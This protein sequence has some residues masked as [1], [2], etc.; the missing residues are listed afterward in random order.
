M[1]TGFANGTILVSAGS[2]VAGAKTIRSEDRGY[3]WRPQSLVIAH[4]N[5]LE[6]NDGRMLVIEYNPKAIDDRPGYYRGKRWISKDQGRTL[7]EVAEGATL[8]LPA[9]KFDPKGVYWFH[10]N[11]IQLPNKQLLTVMQGKE[12]VE[13]KSTWQ[14][15]LVRSRDLG[16]NWEY[17]SIIAD[18]SGLAPIRA[19]LEE[20]GWQLHGAVEPTLASL[21]DGQL[22]CLTR[23]TND[24]SK[25]PDSQ[26]GPPSDS[27][28]DLNYTIS[29][30]GIHPTMSKLPADKFYT[31][32]PPNAPLIVMRSRDDGLHW[33]P[34]VPMRQAR[35]CFPRTARSEDG[36]LALTYGGLG[37]PRWGNCISFSTDGGRNWTDEINFGPFLTTGYTGLVCTGP[38]KFVA[39]FDCTP[40]QPWTNDH[41]WWIGAVDIEVK[42]DR[43]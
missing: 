32:G 41:A 25:I 29:G 18:H 8:H 33:T 31:P 20:N 39:F 5:T 14:C 1:V 6:L 17:V 7:D 36:I 16:E 23:T 26:Y 22:L 10:G 43:P 12:L 30:D 11:L 19:K 27:Y 24:E 37:T 42:K 15:F 21:G 40:P 13:G 2:S 35:G 38:G 4:L 34:P 28:H 9:D 3:S